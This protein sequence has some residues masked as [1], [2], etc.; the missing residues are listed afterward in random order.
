MTHEE[1]CFRLSWVTLYTECRLDRFP[2]AWPKH[3]PPFVK[4]CEEPSTVVSRK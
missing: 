2:V 3:V 1:K 4:I